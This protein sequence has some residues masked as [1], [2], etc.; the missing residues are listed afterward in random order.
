MASPLL[1][2]VAEAAV[3]V[4]KNFNHKNVKANQK[5]ENNVNARILSNALEA[6]RHEG[7]NPVENAGIAANEGL[8]AA[9]NA[10]R[11]WS[12]FSATEAIEREAHRPQL[13]RD[14]KT[15]GN[16]LFKALNFQS[17]L[18]YGMKNSVS[19]PT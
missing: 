13:E 6:A 12:S 2:A 17:A 10:Q 14:T 4:P 15:L 11:E 18:V 7:V 19:K 16:N 5:R 3:F 9:A 8:A 1:P